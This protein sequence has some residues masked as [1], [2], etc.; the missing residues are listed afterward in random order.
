VEL[1]SA[2]KQTS[3]D[4]DDASPEHDSNFES[5]TLLKEIY[6]LM[7]LRTKRPL[8]VSDFNFFYDGFPA[9][10]VASWNLDRLTLDKIS[11]P[12]VLEVI[13]RTIL[14]NR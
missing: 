9:Y 7:S 4:I 14:E 11:N 6:D 8:L 12:G 13:T 3:F 2:K 10:R 5:D 1:V